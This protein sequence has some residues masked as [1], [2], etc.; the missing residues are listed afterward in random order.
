[1]SARTITAALSGLLLLAAAGASRADDFIVYSPY[2]TKGQTELEI[3]GAQLHDGDAAIDGTRNVELSVAHAFTDWWRPEIYLGEYER[4][5][6][7]PAQWVGNEFENVFQLA[8]QG[9][10]WADPGFVLSY[11]QNRQ[12]GEASAI[13]FGPLFE[14]RSGRIDQRLNLIWEKEVGAGASGKYAGRAA[15]A[16]AYNVTRAFAPGFEVY[17]RPGDNAYQM[18]PIV[19]GELASARGTELEYRFGVVFGLNAAAPSQTFL[20]HIEYEFY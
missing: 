17:L 14:K 11:E 6:G 15:Y 1:M 12:P 13:E 7:E 4:A 2:V 9:E 8:P 3:R 19:R 5:P 10:Y 18:G 16:F 20:A